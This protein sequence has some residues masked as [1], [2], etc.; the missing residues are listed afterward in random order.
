MIVL[1]GQVKRSTNMVLQKKTGLRQ[2][3]DQENDITY[4][5]KKIT[6]K[7]LLVKKKTDLIKSFNNLI[8][9]S[10]SDRP[11]PV[12]IDIPVDIQGEKIK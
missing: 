9:L 4:M 11:G 12:W 2:L 3:G 7:T 8:K 10:Y 5:V 1:S 6:K